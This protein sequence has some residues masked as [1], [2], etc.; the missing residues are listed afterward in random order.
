MDSPTLFAWMTIYY[1]Y[2]IASVA[3]HEKL[4]VEDAFVAKNKKPL[5]FMNDGPTFPNP[6]DFVFVALARNDFNTFQE[7]YCN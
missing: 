2:V 1:T 4:I 3:V 7:D 5:L 6:Y